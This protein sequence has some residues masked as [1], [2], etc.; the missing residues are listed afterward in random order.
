MSVAARERGAKFTG[1]SSGR[2][3]AASA[4]PSSILTTNFVGRA[5]APGFRSGLP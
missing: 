2:K 4:A 5:A 1:F 3:F